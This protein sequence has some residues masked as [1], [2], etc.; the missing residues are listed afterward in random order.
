MMIQCATPSNYVVSDWI[1]QYLAGRQMETILVLLIAQGILGAFDTLYFHEWRAKLP[2]RCPLVAPELKLHALRDFLYVVL[3]S[4]LPAVA[5]CGSFAV[6]LALA[7]CVEIGITISDFMVENVVRR[8]LGGVHP[9][10]RFTH[11]LIGINYCALVALLVPLIW[12]WWSQPTALLQT[13]YN[14][15]TPVAWTLDVM[16]VGLFVSGCRDLL[17]ALGVK[18]AAWPWKPE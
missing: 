6:V 9:G 13:A 15:P 18:A 12:K 3:F 1:S 5:W 16:T 2:A 10:E 7:L 11:A 4:T 8:D 14:V 17:C